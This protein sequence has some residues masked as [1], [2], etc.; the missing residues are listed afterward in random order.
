VQYV[1]ELE[2][3]EY[4]LEGVDAS[5]ITFTSNQDLLV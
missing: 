5:A 4:R 3:E 1:F 2:R